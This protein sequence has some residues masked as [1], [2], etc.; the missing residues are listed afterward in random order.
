[1]AYVKGWCR[2]VLPLGEETE[3]GSQSPASHNGPSV[4]ESAQPCPVA[5]PCAAEG[6]G[7]ALSPGAEQRAIGKAEGSV[8]GEIKEAPQRRG[9]KSRC[10]RS[11]GIPGLLLPPAAWEGRAEL[12][13]SGLAEPRGPRVS[14]GRRT[15]AC[16]HPFRWRGPP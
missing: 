10:Q 2:L 6:G 4:P 14:W 13:A 12:G 16:R 15:A 3:Q 9:W 7:S 8:L 1:M 11:G 5:C